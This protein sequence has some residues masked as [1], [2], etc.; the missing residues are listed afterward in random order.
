MSVLS[1][2]NSVFNNQSV[3]SSLSGGQGQF[4]S[5]FLDLASLAMPEQNKNALE[6]CIFENSLVE[7]EGGQL[8]PIEDVCVGMR[9]LTR[10]CRYR[11]VEAVSRRHYSG[12]IVELLVAGFGTTLPFGMTLEH[13]LWIN[14]EAGNPASMK[15]I[16]ASQIEPGDIISTPLRPVGEMVSPRFSGYLLGVYIAEACPVRSSAGLAGTRFTFGEGDEKLGLIQKTQ[17]LLRREAGVCVESLTPNSRP[18]IRLLT[19]YDVEFS[20]WCLEHGGEL[21]HNKKIS[22]EVFHW[23]AEQVLQ[24]LAGWIDGDGWINKDNGNSYATT[25]SKVLATQLMRLSHRIGL[26]PGMLRREPRGKGKRE[27]FRLTFGVAD[28]CRLAAFSLKCKTKEFN[29]TRRSYSIVD[30]FVCRKIEGKT[31]SE[32]DGYVYNLQVEEDHSYIAD[33]LL[34]SNC[35]Y[36]FDMNETYRQAQERRLSY[37]LTD[38][39]VSA[40]STN[41]MLSDDEK[42]KWEKFLVEDIGVMD[43]LQRMNRDNACY[44]NAFVSLMIPFDR[45]LVCP[46]CKTQ[47]PLRDVYNGRDD[48]RFEWQLP[49][50][51][52]TCPVCKVGSGYRG[53][54]KVNDLPRDSESDMYIKLWS[55]HEIEI[56]HDL[57]TDETSYIWRIPEDYKKQVRT[58]H[59]YHLERASMQVIQAIQNNNLF[60]FN[61]NV[62]YHMKERVVSGRRH[63][64]WG[65]S[66]ILINFRQ[67]WYVQVLRRY[68]EAIAL[69]YIIPFRL[70]TPEARSGG[71]SSG[72][73]QMTD[74]LKSVNLG[75]YSAEVMNMIR[76]RRRDPAGWHFLPF[77]VK[78]QALGGD[79]QDLAPHELIDQAYDVMLNGSGVPVDF[80]RGTLQLQTA[81]VALRL[82]EATNTPLVS[83]NNDFLRW[84]A[85]QVTQILSWESVILSLRSVTYADDFNKQMAQLQLMMGQAISQT[86]GLKAMGLDWNEEQRRIAE[87][88]RRQAESQAEI[89]EEMEQN[90][91]GEQIAKGQPMQGGMPGA[92]GG[93]PSIGGDPAAAS[94]DPAAAG[95]GAIDPM[96]GQPAVSPVT[97]MIQSGDVPQSL[98][99]MMATAE[100]LAAE[101]LSL[102][103]TQKDSELRALKNKNEALHSMVKSKMDEMRQQARTAGGAMLLGQGGA[104]GGGGAPM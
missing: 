97:S 86:T 10:K 6:W 46:E 74:P 31:F 20:D 98:D 47:F 73:G 40:D 67:I 77:P 84:L 37:F 68:N 7:L 30:G 103:E 25:V 17:E 22:S 54:F 50:F 96:T 79:A 87:E 32:F 15:R 56:L 94:G 88:A 18:G 16:D 90:A 102:P 72:A 8:I 41:N 36:I 19:P 85:G 45:F 71:G 62:I 48:F 39:E 99:D 11:K 42:D 27:S 1:A 76:K 34:T 104:A 70:L 3:V 82:F 21:S 4:P 78:Y 57:Y 2:P 91:F 44:G 66:R 53:P 9:V 93:A 75:D 100:S 63:R 59:L 29:Y 64:G 81:P 61:K 55:P 24:L 28:T 83:D 43:C 35:E 52:A 95:G 23:P 60:L 33:G 12:E 58:G 5:P 14:D 65:L 38:V 49:N 13:K 51:I 26:T 89:Q 101:L 80:Y 92:M 69:D